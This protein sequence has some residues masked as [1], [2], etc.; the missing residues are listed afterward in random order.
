MAKTRATA[1]RASKRAT[2]MRGRTR[3][4]G[5][6]RSAS[7]ALTR[8][9][10]AIGRTLGDA[11][12]TVAER[13]PWGAGKENAI[14]LLEAD[15][16]RLEEL[17]K[18]GGDDG[19]SPQ[20]TDRHL[21]GDHNRAHRSRTDRREGAVS[22]LEATCGGER[23]CARRLPGASRRRR[24]VEGA[25]AASGRR[26]NDGGRSSRCS[27]RASNITSRK[28]KATCSKRRGRC[29]SRAQLKELGARMR[30]LKA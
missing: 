10:Q 23:D 29:L 28:R 20:T 11:A 7:S 4:K 14:D 1:R 8:T 30:D 27:Q 18:A 22:R 6:A 17:L 25:A 16:R 9:A 2:M 15:H 12:A 24:R 19:S 13:I 21:E 5:R 3:P 26:T